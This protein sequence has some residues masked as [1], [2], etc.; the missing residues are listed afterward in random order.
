MTPSS[1]V[2]RSF[3][4]PCVSFI[5]VYVLVLSAFLFKVSVFTASMFQHFFGIV[6]ASAF[7]CYFSGMF[8]SFLQDCYR[9][10]I[11]SPVLTLVSCRPAWCANSYY[12]DLLFCLG[13]GSEFSDLSYPPMLMICIC[14]FFVFCTICFII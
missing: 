7:L 12:L 2:S 4:L 1:L 8:L 6:Q 3:L 9:K 10:L 14:S 5:P 11:F 13:L